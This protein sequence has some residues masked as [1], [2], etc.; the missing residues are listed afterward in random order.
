MFHKYSLAGDTATLS[1]L[2]AGL[3]HA[4]LVSSDLSSD[5]MT[6][7]LPFVCFMF[8]ICVFLQCVCVKLPF[9]I[10]PKI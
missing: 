8:Y 1:G 6:G 10:F 9:F 3:C 4:F 7:L 5:C 2:Y